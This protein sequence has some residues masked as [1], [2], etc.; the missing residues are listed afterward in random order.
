MESGATPLNQGFISS[1]I[2]RIIDNNT[3]VVNEYDNQMIWQNNLHP[4]HYFGVSHAGY[5]GWAVGAALGIK[6]AAP[7][8]T[9]ITTVGDGSYMFSVP[10]ACHYVSK[11]YDL[12]ILMIVYNNSSWEAVRHATK[13][14]HPDGFAAKAPY[15]PLTELKPSPDYEQICEAFGGYG[16]K[17]DKPENMEGA[18]KRALHAVN[19]EKRQA[20]LNIVCG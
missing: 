20:C 16:E 6:M 12:P 17:V 2:N 9:V 7:S 14:I 3:I 5:L 18:L 4:G 11:A 1:S 19:I 15:M 13:G 10:S 8:K